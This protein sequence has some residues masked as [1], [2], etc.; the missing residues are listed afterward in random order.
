MARFND[1]KLMNIDTLTGN[2]EFLVKDASAANDS[3][4]FKRVSFRG[5]LRIMAEDSA[6]LSEVATAS[7]VDSSSSV[8]TISEDQELFLVEDSSGAVTVSVRN[9]STE[10][11]NTNTTFTGNISSL[12]NHTTDDL[13]EG[14]TNL[15]YTEARI[16]AAVG[17]GILF[18]EY[19]DRA[20]PSKG[21]W[22]YLD[23]IGNGETSL[24]FAHEDGTKDELISR[25]KAI[26]YS[27]IF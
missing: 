1:L 5:M 17:D 27:L 22:L 8:I 24:H 21:T 25:N 18:N 12:A 2:D 15:Y 9:D 10:V 19:T 14:S 26:L 3:A 16:N 20:A 7:T 4:E 6:L 11:I 23:S 13:S